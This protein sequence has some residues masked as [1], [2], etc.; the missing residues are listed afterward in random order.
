[1]KTLLCRRAR[2]IEKLVRHLVAVDYNS[3]SQIYIAAAIAERFSAKHLSMF[4]LLAWDWQRQSRSSTSVVQVSQSSYL[5]FSRWLVQASGYISS[6]SSGLSLGILSYC[7]CFLPAP[8]PWRSLGRYDVSWAG[9]LSRSLS[10]FQSLPL[11]GI[12]T[13]SSNA[14]LIRLPM[15]STPWNC[16]RLVENSLCISMLAM[17]RILLLSLMKT[18]PSGWIENNS[19]SRASY[20]APS[21]GS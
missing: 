6:W 11:G 18:N 12:F 1:M 3:P 15:F 19:I 21:I 2:G 13:V 5:K 7:H 4:V 10:T 8:Q 20:L 14:E 9:F 16:N 17:N